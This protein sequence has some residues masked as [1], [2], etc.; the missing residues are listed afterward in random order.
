M[1]AA[2]FR[3]SRETKHSD[4]LTAKDAKG[5]KVQI[6]ITCLSPEGRSFLQN[7]GAF[8]KLFKWGFLCVL[9]VLC[10][11][12]KHSE[13]IARANSRIRSL[14]VLECP[15]L[16]PHGF[17]PLRPCGES[18]S[19]LTAQCRLLMASLYNRPFTSSRSVDWLLTTY[20]TGSQH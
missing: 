11:E 16:V 6:R 18:L 7:L 9:R 12:R 2:A 10:G 20:E 13:V 8:F 3:L 14:L 1:W 5:R 15:D 17:V 19:C 4:G